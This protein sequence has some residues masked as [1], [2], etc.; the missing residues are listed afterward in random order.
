MNGRIRGRRIGYRAS[1]SSR[2]SSIVCT[3]RDGSRVVVVAVDAVV[4]VV[5]RCL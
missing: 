4:G 3:R 2:S 1:S 5:V